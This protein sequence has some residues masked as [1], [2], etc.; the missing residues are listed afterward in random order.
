MQ[1]FRKSLPRV[2]SAAAA[3]VIAATL[4]VTA[5]AAAPR[6]L[7]PMGYT[8]GIELKTPGV[9]VIG[10]EIIETKNGEL[11]PAKDA[12]IMPGDLI[13]KVGSQDVVSGEEFLTALEENNEDQITVTVDRHGK[14]MQ[15]TV[16]PACGEDG[17]RKL[18]LWLRDT[19]TGIGTMTFYDP[20]TGLY[21]ALGH[22]INDIDSGIIMPLRT[23]YIMDATVVDVHLGECGEPGELCGMFDL[24][25][26]TG[27]ILSNTCSGIFGVLK[28]DCARV[29]QQALPVAEENEIELGA[30]TIL[31]NV[32]G[33]Q[34]EE[35]DVEITRLYRNEESGR[36][37]M[38]R[39]TDP[40][41]LATTG[42][43]VQ[44]MS[45][46]PIIQNG[47][48][49]GAVTHVLVDDPTRGYGTLITTMLCQG[50][51]CLTLEN[52]A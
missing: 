46:S 19:I 48:I 22:S 11:T 41:L 30:A 26:G 52:A 35:Y 42:G 31:S 44:G 33:T 8:V 28:S 1:N 7:V 23:G 36:S 15:F 21:G 51:A 3:I 43:I 5:Q 25:S 32:S 38:I 14:I 49:I 2:A 10:I 12:G 47:K 13:I 4:S 40:D 6:E 45:G 17:E 9:V 24:S 50:E 27:S 16:T 34:V 20:Q 29:E 39:V 37:M 18:G